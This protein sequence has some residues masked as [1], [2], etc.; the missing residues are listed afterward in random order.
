[1]NKYFF[2]KHYQHN[3]IILTNFNCEYFLAKFGFELYKNVTFQKSCT[4][5]RWAL[6]AWKMSTVKIF[7]T[8]G[9]VANCSALTKKTNPEEQ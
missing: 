1:M 9:G 6:Y 3:I 2:Q 5:L 4:N 8:G 7:T